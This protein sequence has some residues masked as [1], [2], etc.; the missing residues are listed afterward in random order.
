MLR[1]LLL[2]TLLLASPIAAAQQAPAVA[3]SDADQGEADGFR[4]IALLTSDPEW[5]E[6]WRKPAGGGG[7]NFPTA[8]EVR[9]GGQ[10]SLVLVL[11]NPGVEAAGVANVGCDVRV[12]RPD[13]SVS[14]DERNVDCFKGE[15]PG[16]PDSLYLAAAGVTF[17]SEPSDPRGVW[18]IDA[19]LTDRVRGVSVPL[20]V[21][22]DVL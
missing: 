10:L 20:Q 12:T 17:L 1:T 13:G 18:V 6:E 14:I 19:T 11:S 4:A 5:M 3:P 2:A 7:P 15:L 22:F 16:G 8:H 9:D 21:A